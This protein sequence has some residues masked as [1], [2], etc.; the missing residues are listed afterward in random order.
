VRQIVS[1]IID[2]S[3][4][5]QESFFFSFLTEPVPVQSAP[6]AIA[7][8]PRSQLVMTAADLRAAIARAAAAK[9]PKLAGIGDLPTKQTVQLAN[10]AK[11]QR[12]LA[13]GNF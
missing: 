9:A 2:Q 1:K 10:T 4:S 11:H 8:K 7:L 13:A 6:V 12:N 3:K 5:R